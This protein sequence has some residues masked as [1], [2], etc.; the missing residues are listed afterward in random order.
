MGCGSV[1]SVS[2]PTFGSQPSFVTTT[3]QY[4]PPSEIVQPLP[5]SID[6]PEIDATSSLIETGLN[7]DNTIETPPVTSPSQAS[8]YRFSPRPGA[9]GP[10]VVLGHVDGN[11]QRGVFYRLRELTPAS[12]I[13][14][15]REDGSLVS[16]EVY[17]NVTVPKNQFP[18]DEVYGDTIEPEIRLITCGGA[19]G[20]AEPGHYD[21]NVIVYAKLTT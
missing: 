18:T 21:N 20:N 2:V 15:E 5:K 3:P 16:F 17:K 7:S 19:F 11:G 14:I 13:V 4:A 8:W 9:T 12:L 1:N 10:A 6:I